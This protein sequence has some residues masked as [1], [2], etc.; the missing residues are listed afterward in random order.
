LLKWS[1][2]LIVSSIADWILLSWA[3]STV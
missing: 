1:Y 3:L 2:T